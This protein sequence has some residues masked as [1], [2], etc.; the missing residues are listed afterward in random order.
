MPFPALPFSSINI[1]LLCVI[2]VLPCL[3]AL[4][5]CPVLLSCLPSVYTFLSLPYFPYLSLLSIMPFCHIIFCNGVLSCCNIILYTVVLPKSHALNGF[6]KCLKRFICSLFVVYLFWL[7]SLILST[8][9][10][11]LSSVSCL[12]HVLSC[13]LSK[14]CRPVYYLFELITKTVCTLFCIPQI[15]I[16]MI[17]A[18]N[19]Q[20]V[21]IICLG[22][23]VWF[24]SNIYTW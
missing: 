2:L 16:S 8:F 9:H 24:S 7:I 14:E 5:L 1:I 12:V 23:T 17:Y 20:K 13:S 21:L 19:A 18:G 4:S 11:T 15:Q 6:W 22:T 3:F 10:H